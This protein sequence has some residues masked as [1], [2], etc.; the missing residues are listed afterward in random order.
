M[1]TFEPV[2]TSTPLFDGHH[3]QADAAGVVFRQAL[4]RQARPVARCV[5]LATPEQV[6]DRCANVV[7]THTWRHDGIVWARVA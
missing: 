4:G 3:L 1:N 2:A 6:E 7:V 5:K